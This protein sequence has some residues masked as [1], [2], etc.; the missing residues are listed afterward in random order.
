MHIAAPKMKSWSRLGMRLKGIQKT[1]NMRSLTA[2]ESK[3]QLVT[4]RMR[5]LSINTAMMSRFPNT[6]RRKMRV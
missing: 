1:A 3:K 4:V 5:L 6:L 2:S